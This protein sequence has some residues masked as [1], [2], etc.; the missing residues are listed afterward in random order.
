MYIERGQLLTYT[1]HDHNVFVVYIIHVG[2][3]KLFLFEATAFTYSDWAER[4]HI[5]HRLSDSFIFLSIAALFVWRQ[6]NLRTVTVHLVIIHFQKNFSF[7]LFHVVSRLDV[8]S[9]IF[10]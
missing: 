10:C 8:R 2:R 5:Q 9:F 7:S 6:F 4:L 1:M 3:N